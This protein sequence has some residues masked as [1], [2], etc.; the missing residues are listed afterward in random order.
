[1]SFG[2]A[3]QILRVD[4]S[5]R[6]SST[7]PVEPYIRSFIGGRGISVKILYDEVDPQ[8]SPFDP[9]NKLF[10]G[11]GVL[12]GTPVAGSSR[13]KVTAMAAGGFLR[14]SG[15]G[16][17]I[18]AEIKRAGYDLIIVQGKSDE[19]VY[20]YIHDDS[21]EFKDASHIWGKDVYETQQ[22]IK[23]ELG[24]VEVMC[25]GPGGEKAVA[26]GSIHTSWGSAAGRCGFG[27]IM[28]SKNLKAIAVRGT[29]GV[30]IAKLEEFLKVAEEQRNSYAS[31]EIAIEG[32]KGGGDRTLAWYWQETGIGARGN[33]EPCSWAAFR[34]TKMDEFAS[35]CGYGP[36]V[37][38]DCPVSHFTNY[39][40]PEIGR[41]G[42]KC[43]PTH[44]VTATLWNPDWKLGFHAYNLM[45]R[46]GLD[47]MSTTN[48]IAFLM[49]LYDRGIITA[50]DTDGIPMRKGDADAI[51]SAI[52]KIGKQE[53][54]GKLFK[55]GVVQG[56][57]KIGRGA[58]EYAMAV[59]ELELQPFE[60]RA[61][62]QFALAAATNT[63]DIIDSIGIQVYFWVEAF[64]EEEKKIYEK[65]AEELYGT[66][67]ASLP[68]SYKGAPVTA[69]GEEG[70]VAAVDMVGVC[71]WLIPW[72][73]TEYLDIPAKLL[74]LATG[75]EMSEADLLFAAQRVVTL[76]RAF[77]VIKGMRRKDD[78]LPKRFFEEP[79]PD[80]PFK[81]ERLLKEKFDKM[82][83]DYYALRGYDKDGIPTEETFRKFGLLSEWKVFKKK[84]PRGEKKT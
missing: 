11:P 48:I 73:M 19:P 20:L 23:D 55:D 35:K 59:K 45:N 32:M 41:G 62:K 27:G 54:F 65:S 7:E 76:E 63:K 66:K 50:K 26:F 68:E 80:G 17:H 84:V 24:P 52:H 6:E 72:Y 83:D 43:T 40:V 13:L 2:W 22:I 70:R 58:K 56:A 64:D 42:A 37:C 12:T 1:M 69:V 9:A 36:E 38:G 53:G 74:S 57:R 15:L 79:V 21:V 61:I 71:K 34:I 47:A 30:K 82:L 16:G 28:G 25:I 51:I 10:F 14:N 77:N 60:Y 31:N 4:L 67:E 46:Y 18:P 75:V 49:E 44:N 8:L 33:W 5:N 39:Y 3:G 81:G 29:R 78:T